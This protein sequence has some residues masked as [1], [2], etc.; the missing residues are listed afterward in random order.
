[1]KAKHLV[2]ATILIAVGVVAWECGGNGACKST[3]GNSVIE[4]S[5]QCDN[6]ASNGPNAPCSSS[7]TL[8]NVA[9]TS[10]QLTYERVTVTDSCNSLPPSASDLMVANA[11][12]VLA[13]PTP[14][15]EMWPVSQSNQKTYSGTL[16]PGVYQATV[17]LLDAKGNALTK[18]KMSMMA[19]VELG[20]PTM[21][22]MVNF[23]TDDYLMSYTGNFDFALHWGSSTGMCMGGGMKQTLTMTKHGSTTPLVAMTNDG[24]KLDGTATACVTPPVLGK[25]Y[26]EVM[27]LPWGHYDLTVTGGQG[28]SIVFC[29]KYDVFVGV[30][31]GTSTCD[32]TV[33]A[34]TPGGDMGTCP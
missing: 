20:N 6:G 27:M 22:L 12:V 11:H 17:T 24:E 23:T 32:L 5:E 10:L 13:G 15:D 29:Q 25:M 9:V 4:C 34:Y 8:Q 3:C 7:C 26:Q 19:D 21:N 14:I 31:V 18:P 2:S 16:M 1:M 28:S 33:E 30:G